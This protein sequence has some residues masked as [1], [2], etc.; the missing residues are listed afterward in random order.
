M[1]GLLNFQLDVTALHHHETAGPVLTIP[2]QMLFDF[3][4]V[5]WR[6]RM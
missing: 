5:D 1:I 2:S 3:D 6:E 4:R